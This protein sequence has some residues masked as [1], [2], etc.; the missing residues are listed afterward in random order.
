MINF[1]I[2]L[3]RMAV[4]YRRCMVGGSGSVYTGITTRHGVPL[5]CCFLATGREAWGVSQLAID[6]NTT[7]DS[8]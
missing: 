6:S 7:G 1:I 4:A 2:F 8:R 5:M 3:W